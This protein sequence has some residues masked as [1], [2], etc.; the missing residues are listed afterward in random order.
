MN[1]GVG[2]RNIFGV[3]FPEKSDP[4]PNPSFQLSATPEDV[5]HPIPDGTT[6]NGTIDVTG[7]ASTGLWGEGAGSSTSEDSF[8]TDASSVFPKSTPLPTTPPPI[9]WPVRR[10]TVRCRGR[11]VSIDSNGGGSAGYLKGGAGALPLGQ[12]SV[13]LVRNLVP[14]PEEG[15]DR[16][17]EEDRPPL[18]RLPWAEGEWDAF[19]TAGVHAVSRPPERE[20]TDAA[21]A[22]SAG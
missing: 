13:T 22:S 19:R 7:N 21:P 6:E 2:R 15:G 8:H 10:P 3:S 12:F 20:E 17:P 16:G 18:P 5:L 11:T 4:A 1:G 9:V 14:P